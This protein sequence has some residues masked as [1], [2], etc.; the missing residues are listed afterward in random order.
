MNAI[1]LAALVRNATSAPDQ[2]GGAERASGQ[3]PLSAEEYTA[4]S[5]VSVR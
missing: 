5:A 4:A 2:S 1:M 3:R